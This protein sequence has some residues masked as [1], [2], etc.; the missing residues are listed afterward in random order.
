MSR[1]KVP[2]FGRLKQAAEV[3]GTGVINAIDDAFMKT[4]LIPVQKWG[5]RA[6]NEM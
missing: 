3:V 6:Q 4:G 5:T 1:V 2:R